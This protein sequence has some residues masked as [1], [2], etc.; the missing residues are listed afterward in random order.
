MKQ[1]SLNGNET[2]DQDFCDGENVSLWLERE[3]KV[4]RLEKS[5]QTESEYFQFYLGLCFLRFLF[6]LFF[7]VS[8]LP[9]YSSFLGIVDSV[10][11]WSIRFADHD[12]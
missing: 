12:M 10:M 11:S 4:F 2:I 9:S 8:F 7:L 3:R 5:L 1:A 6:K